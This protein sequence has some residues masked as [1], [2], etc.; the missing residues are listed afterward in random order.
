M[1]EEEYDAAFDAIGFKKTGH[2]TNL[3]EVRRSSDG[4]PLYVTRASELTPKERAET[5]ERMMRTLCIG[6]APGGGGVH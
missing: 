5:V 1:T 3:S 2:G 4:T 6:F